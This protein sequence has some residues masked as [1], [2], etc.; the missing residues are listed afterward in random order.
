MRASELIRYLQ[1]EIDKHG[2][3]VVELYDGASIGLGP[4][5]DYDLQEDEQ[6]NSV[7]TGFL[8][9]A[10]YWYPEIARIMRR[11]RERKLTKS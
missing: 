1:E 8:I 11:N 4:S 2:D 10:S 6:G 7:V 9:K 3:R 5:L